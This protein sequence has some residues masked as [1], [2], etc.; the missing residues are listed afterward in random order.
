M[1]GAN[2][3]AI[4][5]KSINSVFHTHDRTIENKEFYYARNFIFLWAHL[6]NIVAMGKILHKT[7]DAEILIIT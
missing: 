5:L 4:D 6:E 2:S 7:G 1:E 3:E